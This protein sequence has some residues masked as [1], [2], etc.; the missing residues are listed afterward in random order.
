MRLLKSTTLMLFFTLIMTGPAW[1]HFGMLIPSD[2]MVMQ[3]D[4]RAVMLTLS[5]SHP[6]DMVGMDLVKPKVFDVLAGGK[7]QDLLGTLEATKVMDHQAWKAALY[8]K[9]A[10]RIH[11]LHGTRTVL[12]T[13]RG[14]LYHSLHQ[15]SRNGIWR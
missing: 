3:D 11:V 10:G 4:D 15:N 14:L 1:S 2:S 6:F 13:G 7:K 5:F 12:G 8:G 9:A